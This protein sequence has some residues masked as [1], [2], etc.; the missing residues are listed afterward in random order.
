[1]ISVT[2][3]SLFLTLLLN[4]TKNKGIQKTLIIN[5]K[6]QEIDMKV[7]Y[8]YAD[9]AFLMIFMRYVYVIS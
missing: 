5:E 2:N 8:D 7:I 6:K 3:F 9:R 1:M 4:V